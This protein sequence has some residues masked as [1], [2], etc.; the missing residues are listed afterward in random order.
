MPTWLI[1]I[2]GTILL[3]AGLIA[4]FDWWLDSQ[5]GKR[6]PWIR[7]YIFYK[8][9]TSIV[10]VFMLVSGWDGDY[11]RTPAGIAIFALP[12]VLATTILFPLSTMLYAVGRWLRCRA[13]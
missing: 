5:L 9:L 11:I 7:T 2:T 13:L 1:A 4:M 6:H 3:P 8:A 12:V 10:L